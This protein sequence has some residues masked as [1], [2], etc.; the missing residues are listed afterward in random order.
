LPA[1]KTTL[2]IV[3]VDALYTTGGIAVTLQNLQHV[4]SAVLT[5]ADNGPYI[6]FV[7]VSQGQL[8]IGFGEIATATGAFGELATTVGTVIATVSVFAEGY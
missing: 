2:E 4:H 1:Y 6:P 5:K 7:R 8:Y 3:P